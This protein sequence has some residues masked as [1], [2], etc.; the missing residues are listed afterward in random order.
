MSLLLNG[1]PVERRHFRHGMT[2]PFTL[3]AGEVDF[4]YL[5]C[6]AA[7]FIRAPMTK[8]R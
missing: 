3:S 5:S 6:I 2:T 7:F 4:V 1:V 8:R